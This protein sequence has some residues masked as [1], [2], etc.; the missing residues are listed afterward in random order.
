VSGSAS[1][2]QALAAWQAGRR[3]H[4]TTVARW[5]REGSLIDLPSRD[6]L[7]GAQATQLSELPAPVNAQDAK[8]EWDRQRR[9]SSRSV[10]TVLTQ[11]GRPVHFTTIARWKR[12]G[13]R[14]H[15]PSEHPLTAATTMLDLA[16]PLLTGDPTSKVVDLLGTMEDKYETTR[17][18]KHMPGFIRERYIATFVITK[19]GL[20]YCAEMLAHKPAQLA[21]LLRAISQ[22]TK[23]TS[24]AHLQW[25]NLQLA[26]DGER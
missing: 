12:Q 8:R 5:R 19:L 20:E 15:T 9:P 22:L 3:I 7:A 23:T 17:V 2:V 4:F 11:A 13:W 21:V 26:K 18:D 1:A 16:L 25:L 24:R 14:S 10:A 6:T